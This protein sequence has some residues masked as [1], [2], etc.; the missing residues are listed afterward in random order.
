MNEGSNVLRDLGSFGGLSD[1]KAGCGRGN[2]R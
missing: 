2:N 1:E